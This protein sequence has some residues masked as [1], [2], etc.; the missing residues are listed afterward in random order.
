LL[1][2]AVVRF[3]GDD[4][5]GRR[6]IR[7]TG[8]ALPPAPAPRHGHALFIHKDDLPRLRVDGCIRAVAYALPYQRVRRIA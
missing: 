4:G 6:F 8:C 1:C 7:C 5:M 3:D 2:R